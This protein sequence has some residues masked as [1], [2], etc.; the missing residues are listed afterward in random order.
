MA[1]VYV[2]GPHTPL[3]AVYAP[4]P[5]C[6]PHS[7]TSIMSLTY[8]TSC[9]P[10]ITSFLTSVTNICHVCLPHIMYQ[11]CVSHCSAWAQTSKS[12]SDKNTT[13]RCPPDNTSTQRLSRK[14]MVYVAQCF[15]FIPLTGSVLFHFTAAN[16]VGQV[17]PSLVI[18]P[19][20]HPLTV[21]L[22]DTD[23]SPRQPRPKDERSMVQFVTQDQTSLKQHSN[24][25]SQDR[26]DG[27][28]HHS[29]SDML[30]QHSLPCVIMSWQPTLCC[31][32]MTA[33]PVLLC[34]NSLPD[35]V[36]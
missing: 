4:G 32:V 33:C 2:A 36:M 20:L 25:N 16:C 9:L 8:L 7:T 5:S 26:T 23:A 30:K 14:Q 6:L 34:N 29:G 28:V 24:Q 11:P 13:K 27:S 22:V 31:Y 10:R 17:Q 19:L 15:P 12:E 35:V 3:P 1:G 18:M 21:V